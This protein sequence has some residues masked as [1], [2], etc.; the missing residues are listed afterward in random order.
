MEG[1]KDYVTQKTANVDA[2]GL[3]KSTLFLLCSTEWLYG[4][5]YS[6]NEFDDVAQK[7]KH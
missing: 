2:N 7:R 4:L 6:S 3:A 5:F 1:A